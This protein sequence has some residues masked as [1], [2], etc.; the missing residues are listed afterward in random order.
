M[1]ERKNYS[2]IYNYLMNLDELTE[3]EYNNL[4]SIYGNKDI[5]YIIEIIIQENDRFLSKFNYYFERKMDIVDSFN[6]SNL[7]IYL[8]EIGASKQLTREENIRYSNEAYQIVTTLK[9]IF[10]VEFDEDYI[11]QDGII[12]NSI[13][14][15][16]DFYLECC[17]DISLSNKLIELKNRYIEVRN[18]LVNGNLRLVV[19]ALKQYYTDKESY[20]DII[21]NGNIGLMRAVEKYDPSY[22]TL[23]VTYAY[24]WVRM[25]IRNFVKNSNVSCINTSYRAIEDNNTKLKVVSILTNK[26]GREPT[27]EEI[28]SYMGISLEK[29][30]TLDMTFR[31]PMSLYSVVRN[32]ADGKEVQLMEVIEDRTINIE[33][34]VCFKIRRLQFINYLRKYL[35]EKQITILLGRYGFY[36]ELMTYRELGEILNM[37]KQAVDMSE[38]R[39]LNK[40]RCMPRRNIRDFLE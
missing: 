38:K 16:V 9:E 19:T 33:E 27:N 36:G 5:D 34:D 37:S 8:K 28:S 11:K 40:I 35:S 15:Q 12:F 21:Q 31:N 29:L 14:D 32:Y 10:D 22:N 1:G 26:L 25:S 13:V 6:C 4:V 2:D 7:E 23:F 17:H 30:N 18:I 20:V 3:L 39:A 24:Y